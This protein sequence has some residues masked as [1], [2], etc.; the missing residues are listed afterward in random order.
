MVGI[1]YF[2]RVDVALLR[3][4]NKTCQIA[5]P[6]MDVFPALFLEL[7]YVHVTEEKLLHY[8]KR[9]YLRVTYLSF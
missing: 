1:K 6:D 9:V 4:L 3:Q 5:F 8:T 7:L 2:R